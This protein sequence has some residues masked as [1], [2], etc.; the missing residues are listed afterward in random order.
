MKVNTADFF[1]A[2]VAA[3]PLTLADYGAYFILPACVLFNFFLCYLNTNI[4]AVSVPMIIA[5]EMVL[6]GMSTLLGFF[7]LTRAK[8]YWLGVIVL[9]LSLMMALS[10]A[11]DEFLMKPIRDLII[12]PVFVVL[13]LTAARMKPVPMILWLSALIALVAMW[14]AYFLET[15]TQYFNIRQYYVDKGVLPDDQFVPLDLAASGVRPNQRYILDLPFHRLSSVFLEPVS[16]GFFGFISGLFFVAMK[17]AVTFKAFIAGMILSYFLIV[18]SDARMAF[19]ALTLV[20]LM[21][22]VFAR[23]DHR[24]AALI[25]PSI[26]ILGAVIYLTQALGL[27]EEG[28][29]WR[30]NDTFKKLSVMDFDLFMGLSTKTYYAEDSALLKTFQY[31]GILGLMIFWLAPILFMRRLSEEPRIY[32]YGMTIFLSFGFMISSAILTIKTASFLWFLYGYL[33][34]WSVRKEEETLR[35]N[36]EIAL[37]QADI[38]R[39]P[40]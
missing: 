29:G 26:F 40:A 24:F 10:L 1:A 7:T 5:C 31:Q 3:R 25:F 38:S 28:I 39:R 23:I 15:F 16:L 14:E 12:M 27:G 17:K 22:P 37:L 34:A 30:I 11:R 20:L 32:L 13:G 9:Q 21:R 8:L 18:I 6:V 19:G 35:D 33:I 36:D 2:P 4:M